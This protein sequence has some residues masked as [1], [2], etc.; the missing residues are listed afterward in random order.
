MHTAL[1]SRVAVTVDMYLYCYRFS[2]QFLITTSD[3]KLHMIFMFKTD[4][5]DFNIIVAQT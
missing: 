5:I 1:T 2:V 3:A 4:T